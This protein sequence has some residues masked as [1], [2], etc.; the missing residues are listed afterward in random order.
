[1][2]TAAARVQALVDGQRLDAWPIK[3]LVELGRASVET[4]SVVKQLFNLEDSFGGDAVAQLDPELR[5]PEGMEN[6]ILKALPDGAWYAVHFLKWEMCQKT[7]G[8][9]NPFEPLV[10]ILEHGGS[11]HVE[12]AMYMDITAA[13]SSTAGICVTRNKD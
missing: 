6:Q 12:H 11:M 3:H 4:W 5:L 1:M 9:D 8:L 13:D 10:Q 2:M 7:N